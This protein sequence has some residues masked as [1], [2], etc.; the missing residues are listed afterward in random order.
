MQVHPTS[1]STVS[2]KSSLA[3]FGSEAEAPAGFDKQTAVAPANQ[4]EHGSRVF[5]VTEITPADD[6]EQLGSRGGKMQQ[7]A[8]E[9]AANGMPCHVITV[10]VVR[11]PCCLRGQPC[12]AELPFIHALVERACVAAAAHAGAEPRFTWV[13]ADTSATASWLQWLGTNEGMLAAFGTV[14]VVVGAF[15]L[16][17]GRRR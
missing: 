1:S 3:A 6:A 2:E 16:S 12:L 4:G 13:P 15:M 11:K 14:A 9:L 7:L 5:A 17:P 8:P 10:D